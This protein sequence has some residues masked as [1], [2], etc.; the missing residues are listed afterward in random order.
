M[1][2]PLRKLFTVSEYQTMLESGILHE[3]DRVELIEGEIWQMP[4]IGPPHYSSVARLDRVFQRGL[5]DGLAVIAV[6]SSVR[7]GDFS[8]PEPDL[9]VLRFRADFYAQT[10]P[11]ASDILLLV[12][13]ADSSLRYDQ[14][15]KMGLYA[16]H[17]VAEV[18]LHDVV[19]EAI[20]VHRDP[21]PQ[22]YRDVRT[23]H[24]GDRLA[25][26][27]FPDLV[28]LQ[29]DTLLGPPFNPTAK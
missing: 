20:V 23:L 28:V 1:A 25:P 13:V 19:H 22:G 7:L 16:R 21:S 11:T 8:E 27:A 12:E 5:A 9:A 26:L 3:D 15:V 14:D 2:E 18:W 24:R 10:H 6:Q 17:G 4:P 29:V